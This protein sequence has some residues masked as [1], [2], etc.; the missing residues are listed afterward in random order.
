MGVSD[1]TKLRVACTRYLI[2]SEECFLLPW[3]Q[4][5]ISK[6]FSPF[7]FFQLPF[8]RFKP[9]VWGF[10]SELFIY[11][12]S[13]ITLRSVVLILLCMAHLINRSINFL[14]QFCILP[15]P[16][17]GK[18]VVVEP[19]SYLFSYLCLRVGLLNLLC[20]TSA[21][22]DSSYHTSQVIRNYIFTWFLYIHF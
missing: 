21:H 18:I 9:L 7:Y 19:Y 4:E 11:Y 16:W 22:G 20:I 6:I 3:R 12:C 2:Y 10:L 8:I 1:K 5:L 15:T 17:A 14:L 13:S